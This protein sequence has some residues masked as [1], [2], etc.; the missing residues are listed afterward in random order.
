VIPGDADGSQVAA[1]VAAAAA[2]LLTVS[3]SFRLVP[4]DGGRSTPNSGPASGGENLSPRELDVLT[5]IADGLPNKAIA[6]ELGISENTVKFHAA[7]ILGKLGAAS[8]AEAVMLAARRGLL[9]V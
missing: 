1:A 4:G 2:G 7:S 3:P 6:L 5:L 8:R 9:A